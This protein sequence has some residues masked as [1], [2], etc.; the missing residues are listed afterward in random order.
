[1]SATVR[2]PALPNSWLSVSRELVI[3]TSYRCW[4]STHSPD[5]RVACASQLSAPNVGEVRNALR[6]AKPASSSR[7]VPDARTSLTPAEKEDSSIATR[8]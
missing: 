3:S 5:W 1:M 8:P 2:Q 6:L 4:L 7:A